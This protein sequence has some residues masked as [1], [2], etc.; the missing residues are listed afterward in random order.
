MKIYCYFCDKLQEW[1][2]RDKN[3]YRC[4]VCKQSVSEELK[5]Y[6]IERNKG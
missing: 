2:R 5:K 6:A 1:F 4:T 3:D